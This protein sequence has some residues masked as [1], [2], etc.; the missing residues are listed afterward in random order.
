MKTSKKSIV[1]GFAFLV[2]GGLSVLQAQNGRQMALTDALD[3]GGKIICSCNLFHNC[4]ASGSS[5]VCAQSAEG[6]NIQCSS[7]N[8]NC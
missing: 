1:L 2:F 8:S 4:K 3:G 7:Y 5:G 6:E